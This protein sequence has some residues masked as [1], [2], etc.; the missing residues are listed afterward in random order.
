MRQKFFENTI[1]SKFIKNLLL[2]TSLPIFNSVSDGDYIIKGFRYLYGN[3][4]LLC[5]KSGYIGNNYSNTDD[6]SLVPEF[7]VV[8]RNFVL[9]RNYVKNTEYFESNSNSYDSDTHTFLGKYLRFYRD[10]Y[11]TNL[12]PFYN[13]FNGV[14]TSRFYVDKDDNDVKQNRYDY[15]QQGTP[16]FNS[17]YYDKEQYKVTQIP[18]RFNKEYTIAVDCNAEVRIT[19]CFIKNNQLVYI[20]YGGQELDLTREFLNKISPIECFESMNF[21]RPKLISLKN[22]NQS[23]LST[24]YPEMILDSNFSVFS[25]EQLF[26]TYEADLYLLIQLPRDNQSSIVVL[27]GDYTN[28]D[29]GYIYN[30]SDSQTGVVTSKYLITGTIFDMSSISS[31]NYKDLD[32]LLTSG[33]SLLSINDNVRYPYSDSLIQYLLWNAI[34][35]NEEISGNVIRIQRRLG[36]I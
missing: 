14:Y 33:L 8:N 15:Y 25:M 23:L 35:N 28:L 4:V 34:D 16:K 17:E 1:Q 13:C 31:M 5:T 24:N 19:P 36:L 2:N 7:Q 30:Y 27:E 9:G 10:V 12:M 11:K 6:Q 20:T 26:Q 21:K 3:Q 22:T 18:V 29:R 32:K